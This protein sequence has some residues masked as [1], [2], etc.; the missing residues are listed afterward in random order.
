MKHLFS[1]AI[2]LILVSCA[3]PIGPEIS[4]SLWDCGIA[5]AETKQAEC[6]G[7]IGNWTERYT[8]KGPVRP[9]N[10]NEAVPNGWGD[11][12][13]TK[14]NFS[15]RAKFLLGTPSMAKI[16]YPDGKKFFGQV[17]TRF[18]L[19]KGE[20]EY[21]SGSKFDG[22]FD[23]Y[24]N[25]SDGKYIFKNGSVFEGK[26]QEINN[27]VLPKK[28]DYKFLSNNCQFNISGS[29]KKNGNSF[30]LDSEKRFVIKH[31]IA[32]IKK[33]SD[34]QN[35]IKVDFISQ[36]SGVN[37]ELKSP[38]ITFDNNKQ[39]TSISSS[40]TI[41]VL[42]ELN[43]QINRSS[44]IW[45]NIYDCNSYPVYQKKGVFLGPSDKRVAYISDTDFDRRKLISLGFEFIDKNKLSPVGQVLLVQR[46]NRNYDRRITSRTDEKSR[47]ISGQREI[48]NPDYDVAQ[49][50]VYSAQAKLEAARRKDADRQ[51]EGCTAGFGACLLAEI[52]LNETINAE[53]EYEAALAKLSKTPRIKV[54]NVYSEY[55]VEK[56]NI[57]AEKE[58]TLQFVY[59]DFDRNETFVTSKSLNDRKTFTV[60]NS[61]V[62]D[63]D[64]NKKKLL[65]GTSKEGEVDSWMTKPINIQGSLFDYFRELKV[66]P[67]KEPL[68][69]RSQINFFNS[70]QNLNNSSQQKTSIASTSNKQISSSDEYI[71]ENSILVVDTLDGAGTGFY[72]TKNHII[73]N[74]HVVEDSGYVNFKS[75]D[76]AIFSGRVISTDI[77]SDLALISTEVEGIP[78][79]LENNC[80]VKRRENVFT[81]G[82]PQGFEYTTS[83]GIVSS[84]RKMPNPFYK[85]VGNKQYIQ[86][87]ASISSGNS[88]G[89]LFNED[90]K[91]IGVNTWGRIDGQNLNF[92][93][94]C[95][96]VKKFALTNNIKL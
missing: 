67:N 54:E 73:T 77:A 9:V 70:L 13:D 35:S 12:R 66:I 23:N 81:V 51:S 36:S 16:D 8:Y 60:I 3:T 92:A 89:P 49:A 4:Y 69:K 24:G 88:G 76:G 38:N 87:D 46:I 14:T 91:V 15:F 84:I 32:L 56:L 50:K 34:V 5:T 31:P 93:V 95:S 7:N 64:T 41:L 78:L 26:M 80:R 21:Q 17:T 45:R 94:H 75:W 79:Q 30:V 90:E 40:E 2:A 33:S 18:R 19:S 61:E 74:Q 1:A 57:E 37:F 20:L 63:T 48:Y 43:N 42:E 82:H 25:P 28:G 29:F 59:F 86:I 22:K 10:F 85:A 62:A 55:L 72:V 6:K 96:E 83:R 39:I 53:N 58:S 27:M 11:I 44:V 68:S 71:V 52:I 65:S 47:Y